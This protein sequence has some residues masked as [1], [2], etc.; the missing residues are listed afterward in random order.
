ML[1]WLMRVWVNE[2]DFSRPL[3]ILLATSWQSFLG[4]TAHVADVY[5]DVACN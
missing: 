1:L 3:R 5:A 4:D 2:S